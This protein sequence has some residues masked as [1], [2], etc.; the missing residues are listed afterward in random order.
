MDLAQRSKHAAA[1]PVEASLITCKQ[2][3][4][5]LYR[6]VVFSNL[7][8]HSELGGRG[9][10]A[11]FDG[12]AE[13]VL[14]RLDRLHPPADHQGARPGAGTAILAVCPSRSAFNRL[15]AAPGGPLG[16]RG[17]LL[18]GRGQRLDHRGD[19]RRRRGRPDLG[20]DLPH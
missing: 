10:Q 1:V 14:A 16:V 13:Q 17:R 2:Q 9:Q 5:H 18:P 8:A 6:L 15:L 12:A 4:S 19:H 11:G 20:R 3:E 7:P